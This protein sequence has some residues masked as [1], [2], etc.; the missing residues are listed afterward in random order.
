MDLVML[1]LQNARER[2]KDD[3]ASLFEQAD[4]K[5]RFIS[6]T[7]MEKSATAVIVAVWEGT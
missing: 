7:A 4:K 3:W 5:F 1:T 2:E 6:A